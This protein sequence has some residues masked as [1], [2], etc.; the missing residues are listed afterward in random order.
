MREADYSEGEGSSSPFPIVLEL[1]NDAA[2]PIH[3]VNAVNGA[4]GSESDTIDTAAW[5][6]RLP[7]ESR[8]DSFLGCRKE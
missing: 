6:I 1:N 3:P 4:T 2:F 7:K 5:F 8:M